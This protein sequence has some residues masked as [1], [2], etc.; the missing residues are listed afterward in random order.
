MI[1]M[2]HWGGSRR[3]AL[4]SQSMVGPLGIHAI[5]Q[6]VSFACAEQCAARG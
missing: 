3:D 2:V 5:R 4:H 1:G 6:I